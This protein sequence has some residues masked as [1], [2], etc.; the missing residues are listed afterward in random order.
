MTILYYPLTAPRAVQWQHDCFHFYFNMWNTKVLKCSSYPHKKSCSETFFCFS[1]WSVLYLFKNSKM[2]T[3]FSL[4][5]LEPTVLGESARCTGGADLPSPSIQVLMFPPAN[6]DF[7]GPLIEASSHRGPEDL[8]HTTLNLS[9]LLSQL[10]LVLSCFTK[11][12]SILSKF[13]S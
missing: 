3:T 5:N 4:Y 12:L 11:N 10:T 9:H 2:L 13:F 1:S 8:G 7:M 6:P